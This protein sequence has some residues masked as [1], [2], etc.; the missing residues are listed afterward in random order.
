[1]SN[2]RAWASASAANPAARSIAAL[3]IGATEARVPQTRLVDVVRMIQDEERKIEA[4]IVTSRD[5]LP[6]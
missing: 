3:A 6:S 5:A 4:I 1:M 2:V